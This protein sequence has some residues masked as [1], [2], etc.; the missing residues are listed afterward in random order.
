M[1]G[2]QAV[3]NIIF[4]VS[5]TNDNISSD[6]EGN[7]DTLSKMIYGVSSVLLGL[8]IAN[9]VL[10]VFALFSIVFVYRGAKAFNKGV[11]ASWCTLGFFMLVGWLVTTLIFA[12][13]VIV[14]ESCDVGN[15]I[16]KDPVFFNKTFGYIDNAFDIEESDFN[17]TRDVLYTCFHGDGDLAKELNLSSNVADFNQI[18]TTVDEF[19]TLASNT[20]GSLPASAAALV[21]RA[22]LN[23]I[24]AGTIPDSAQYT[25]PD[26]LILNALTRSDTNPC[27]SVKDAWVL[28]SQT[29]TSS[30]GNTFTSQSSATYNLNSKTCIG[31]NMWTA[32]G[33][34]I[35]NRYTSSQF[36]EFGCPPIGGQAMY[37]Y[38]QRYVRSLAK[39]RAQTN[40]AVNRILQDLDK[41]DVLN[42]EFKAGTQAVPTEIQSLNAIVVSLF[43]ELT[44]PNGII[45]TVNCKFVRNDFEILLDN[46]CTGLGGNMYQITM[47]YLVLSF[48]TLAGVSMLFLLAKRSAAATTAVV[49]R[50]KKRSIIGI[51][52]IYLDIEKV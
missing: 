25:A 40:V 21:F 29:C 12:V 34:N 38:V 17:R 14:S 32:A 10:G 22:Y 35:D 52:K 27:T 24:K 44:A 43:S 39:N 7:Q 41:I 19:S 42:N 5:N 20:I 15:G 9:V 23:Q 46:A 49:K 50:Q 28:N 8:F 36:P 37:R 11:H 33:N 1:S 6:L 51:Q 2:I 31:E 13:T 30:L 47:V 45:N 18:F 3:R 26:L 4:Q 16:T 48:A